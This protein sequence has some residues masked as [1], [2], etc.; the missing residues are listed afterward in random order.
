MNKLSVF[1]VLAV[2]SLFLGGC[3]G[4]GPGGPITADNAINGYPPKI[5]SVVV[6][7]TL[8]FMTVNYQP[9]DA[10]IPRVQGWFFNTDHG[11]SQKMFVTVNQ[12]NGSSGNLNGQATFI[13]SNMPSIPNVPVMFQINVV[14]PFAS[15]G[16]IQPRSITQ[17][18]KFENGCTEKI[19][20]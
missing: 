12:Q 11:S 13:L 17:I 3:G 20:G 15:N 7:G 2:F 19:S 4:Y 10:P 9:F 14:E 1:I 8:G 18:W 6:N 5:R 16:E